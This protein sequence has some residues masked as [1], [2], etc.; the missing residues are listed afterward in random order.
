MIR[1]IADFIESWNYE[2]AS[3]A[4]I[5]DRLTQESLE[6]RVTP[7]GRSIRRLA[8]HIVTTLTE[9]PGEAGTEG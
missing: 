7:D 9:M 6:Q 2:S 8:W 3:T 4:K 1:T 5:F